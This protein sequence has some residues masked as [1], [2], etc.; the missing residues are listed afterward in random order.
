MLM[1]KLYTF[2]VC[3]LLALSGC[4]EFIEP[5]IDDKKVVLLAPAAGIETTDYAQNFSWE[6]VEYALNYRLQLV[7][8]NFNKTVKLVLDTV[9]STTKFKYTLDPGTYEWRVRAQN[10]S[11]QTDYTIAAFT[12]Y[13]TSISEQRV[14]M[15][16][17]ASGTVTNQPAVTFKW[18]KLYGA[19]QYQIQVDTTGNDFAD[20][21]TLFLNKQTA[22]L[23]F[24]TSFT[25]DKVYR[26]RLRA[27]NGA[28]ESKWSIAAAITYDNT[29]PAVV[30]LTAPANKSSNPK[31]VALK[32]NAVPGVKNYILYVYKNNSGT[33]YNSTFPLNTTSLSYSFNAGISGEEIFWEVRAID[34]AGNL[35]AL[36]ELRSFVIQ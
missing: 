34:E 18:L 21:S 17:P 26:W 1:K 31:P 11:S 7:T 8:P 19:D 30:E 2:L 22:N 29:A 10:G 13:P 36:G 4:T 32:W 28:V 27:L 33:L 20:E 12:V 3:A 15:D 24:S 25:K 9:V 14:Q 5:S 35:S 6:E 23:E 16:G